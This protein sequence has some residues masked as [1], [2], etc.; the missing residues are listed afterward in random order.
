[1]RD[2]PISTNKNRPYLLQRLQKCAC[3]C[4]LQGGH[5]PQCPMLVTPLQLRQT[6]ATEC[7]NSCIADRAIDNTRSIW[8]SIY[9]AQHFASVS[10]RDGPKNS[11][12]RSARFGSATCELFGTLAK[13]WRHFGGSAF[14]AFCV[15]LKSLHFIVTVVYLLYLLVTYQVSK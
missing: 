14:A 15:N 6:S 9:T 13:T 5:V 4:K 10:A 2:R 1:M 3:I 12:E 11:A 7:L 8:L